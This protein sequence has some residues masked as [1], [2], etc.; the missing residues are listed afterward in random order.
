MDLSASIAEYLTQTADFKRKCRVSFLAAGEYNENYLVDSDIGKFVFRVNHGSQLGLS[1]Q[2][3]Y[4]YTVLQAVEKSGVT[5]RPLFCDPHPP[6][7]PSGVLLMEYLPGEPL[8]YERD[9]KKAAEVFA[10]IHSQPPD[11]RLI[12]QP[13]PIRDIAVESLGLFTRHTDHPL[14]RERILLEKYHQ[15]IL[16][17]SREFGP[18]FLAEPPVMVNTEV[19]SHNF[20]VHNDSACLVDWEKAVVSSRFQDLGHFLV[21]TTTR[22]K[23]GTTL[24]RERKLDFLRAYARELAETGNNPPDLEELEAKTSLL[25]K[26]ILLR[27]LSWC[28]MAYYEYTMTDRPIKNQDTFNKIKEFLSESECFL[29]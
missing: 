9:L 17:L 7:L 16:D 5:P 11:S 25:E 4:E 14:T 15:K 3:E 27:A 6:G 2:I 19:N 12:A 20:L 1:N 29:N 10:R 23:T 21:V 13:D 26:T 8:I 18:S 22:W 24:S 28:Y